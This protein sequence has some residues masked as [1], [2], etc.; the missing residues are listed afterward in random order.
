MYDFHRDKERYFTIQTE[1]A[2]DFVIPFIESAVL[3]LKEQ[4]GRVLEI[5]CGEGGVLQAFLDKGYTCVGVERNMEKYTIAHKWMSES[6]NNGSLKLFFKDIHHTTIEELG[7]K[8]DVIVLKDVIE[9][10]HNRPQILKYMATLLTKNG[11]IFLGFPPWQMPYGGHQQMCVSKI[12]QTPYI[13]LLPRCLYRWILRKAKEDQETIDELM[14]VVSTRISIEKFMRLCRKTN[15]TI[16]SKKF[17]LINPIYRW[18]FNLKPREQFR[19]IRA[20]PFFR[21]FVTTCVYYLIEQ[22]VE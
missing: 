9:H 22:K 3:T 2:R 1:N 5:G 6:I 17:Y 13:H 15:Y 20:L 14:D 4:K 19:F 8:F 12:G 11:V 18:K 21:N 16:R 10:L 7:G